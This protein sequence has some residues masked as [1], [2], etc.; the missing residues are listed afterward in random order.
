MV[1]EVE[2]LIL[3]LVVDVVDVVLDVEDVVVLVVEDL[4]FD[5][6]LDTSMSSKPH[7]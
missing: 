7:L 2:D 6:V 4:V 3:V 1:L 5:L